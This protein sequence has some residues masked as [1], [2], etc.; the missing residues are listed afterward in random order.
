[1]TTGLYSV[2]LASV[3]LRF[4]ASSSLS[5]LLVYSLITYKI[6]GISIM[7]KYSREGYLNKVRHGKV[8]DVVFPSQLQDDV[9]MQQVIALEQAGS[10]AAA[11]YIVY[12][13]GRYFFKDLLRYP[14]GREGVCTPG[15]PAFLAHA[16]QKF[17]KIFWA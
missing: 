15:G 7:Y 14:L 6:K 1:M 5:T 16:K 4:S 8:H 9:R 11:A 12:S 13:T 17:N 10:A 2:S 3:T